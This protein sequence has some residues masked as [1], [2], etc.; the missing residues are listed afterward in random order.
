[1]LP[2]PAHGVW[3]D[4]RPPTGLQ[5]SFSE[6]IQ[7]KNAEWVAW[8]W[9]ARSDTILSSVSYVARIILNTQGVL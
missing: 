9:K 4:D 1:M 7:R 6:A 2:Y 8:L 3:V 5:I